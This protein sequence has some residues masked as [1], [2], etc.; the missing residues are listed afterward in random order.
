M[1]VTVDPSALKVTQDKDLATHSNYTAIA[2]QHI[3]LDWTIDWDAKVFHGQAV[4]TLEG[5]S[6]EDTVIL[7]VSYLDIDKVIIGGQE[8]K[9][10]VGERRGNAGSPLTIAL[11]ETLN[12]GKVGQLRSTES[13]GRAEL[14]LGGME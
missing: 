4:L 13:L 5:I 6:D 3:H 9:W 8:V 10:T 2:T 11:P 14:D 12:P 7:D 1:P